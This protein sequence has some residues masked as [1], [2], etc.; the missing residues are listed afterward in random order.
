MA[1]NKLRLALGALMLMAVSGLAAAQDSDIASQSVD[2]M[3]KLF[4]VHPGFRANHAKGVVATGTFK[5]TQQAAELSKATLF[6]GGGIPAT[7][8][9]SDATGVPNVPDGSGEANPHGLAIKF[10]LPDGGETDMVT[11]SLKFFPVSTAAEF[12]DLL[13]ALTESPPNAPKPTKFEQFLAS[14]PTAPRAFATPKTP[15]SFADEEYYGINAFVFVNN[16]GERQ[17]VRYVVTPEKIVHL[18]AAEA[19]KKA[20]NFLVDE[21][22][23]R[24]AQGPVTF[25][26]KAQLASPGE[27]TNDPSHTWRDDDKIVELGT[28][29]IDKVA[30]DSVEAQKKLLFLPGALTEGIEPSDDPMIDARDQAYA[31][32]FSRRNP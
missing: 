19:A 6:K 28:L 25:R 16:K 14:H 23:A 10:H 7:V 21:L 15:A 27:P 26:L 1:G 29:T 24:L 18:D 32:S 2:A 30:P 12:R 4:G 8:R 5:P 31:I 13:L 20:P 17:A 3:N 9:F 22:A 11:N